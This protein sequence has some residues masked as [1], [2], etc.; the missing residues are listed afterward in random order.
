MTKFEPATIRP[1][2]VAFKDGA[3]YSEQFGDI[4][5]SVDG[6]I[7]ESSHVFLGGND[8]PQRWHH[9]A[10]F[11]IVETGFGCGLNFLATWDALK[12]SGT[13]CRLDFVS[14][15]KHPFNHDDLAAILRAWPQLE[16][17]SRELL[18]AYPPLVPGFHR[19]HFDEGRVT[20]TL[21]FGDALEADG[22]IGKLADTNYSFSY[23]NDVVSLV[24]ETVPEFIKRIKAD[25]I[26]VLFLVPV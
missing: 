13:A 11:T 9:A 15:E 23:V 20:L 16:A 18:Q 4:Y 2:Q 1:A 5:H 8:L 14:V 10:N 3:L 24:T 12:R 25:R 21:L 19:L 22:I 7:A 17:F 6:A 26:D